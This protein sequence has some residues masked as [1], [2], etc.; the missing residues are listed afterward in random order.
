MVFTTFWGPLG[1]IFGAW[2]LLGNSMCPPNY[3]KHDS[4]TP[5]CHQSAL[6]PAPKSGEISWLGAR[7]GDRGYRGAEA[8]WPGAN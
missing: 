2:G 6:Q 8:E 7:V 4:G 5:L 1:L 3:F